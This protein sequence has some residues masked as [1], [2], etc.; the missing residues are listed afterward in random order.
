M[1]SF[2]NT[3]PPQHTFYE[4]EVYTSTLSSSPHHKFI[5]HSTLACILQQNLIAPMVSF[6]NT[7]PPHFF[8]QEVST[9][10]F[11]SI[12]PRLFCTGITVTSGCSLSRPSLKTRRPLSFI[13]STALLLLTQP[14]STSATRIH[15][16]L[17]IFS[18]ECSKS[19]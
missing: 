15:C 17:E 6:Q 5:N 14:T 1:V 19:R 10:V 4:Q 16:S 12:T 8:Q 18:M 13:L 2:Q 9:S 7:P 11:I 3:Q